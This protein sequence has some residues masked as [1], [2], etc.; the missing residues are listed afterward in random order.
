MQFLNGRIN[1][2]TFWTAFAAVL[3]IIIGVRLVGFPS[4]PIEIML[5]IICVPRMHDVGWSARWLLLPVAV[6]TIAT[7]WAGAAA[8]NPQQVLVVAYTGTA[9]TF[10]LMGWLGSLKGQP[11]G[12]SYGSPP[13]KGLSFS[14]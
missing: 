1:R 4:K 13:E 14:Q 6:V 12:N 7:M 10:V 11:E 3:A 2:A 5:C 9:A 8:A